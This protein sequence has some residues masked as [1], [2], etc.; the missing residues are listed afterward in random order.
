VHRVPSHA[1]PDEVQ[2]EVRAALGLDE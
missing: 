2:A 1:G